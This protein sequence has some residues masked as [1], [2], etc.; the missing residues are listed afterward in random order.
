MAK[1]VHSRK[2]RPED[3]DPR[4]VDGVAPAEESTAFA[5]MTADGAVG[6]RLPA[7]GV[8]ML[9]GVLVDSGASLN[10][11]NESLAKQI[12]RCGNAEARWS[13]GKMRTLRAFNGARVHCYGSCTITLSFKDEES[14]EWF[15]FE[16]FARVIS[17]ADCSGEDTLILGNPFLKSNGAELNYSNNRVALSHP[18]RRI[19]F[20]A[21]ISA[22]QGVVASIDH[23]SRPFT[24]N[25]IDIVIPAGE[26]VGT[27]AQLPDILQGET[28][29]LLPLPD[30]D[31]NLYA[32]QQGLRLEYNPIVTPDADGRVK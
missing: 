23:I 24:F 14:A 21:Q 6:F 12:E 2:Q 32:N 4:F 10:V 18:V 7:R 22:R 28:V 13:R 1:V 30:A 15:E 19:N 3:G 5:S 20:S 17:D 25:M 29:T 11:I 27:E 26:I 16:V 31:A 8:E 9:D